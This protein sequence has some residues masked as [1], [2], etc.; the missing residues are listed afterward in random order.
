LGLFRNP[1]TFIPLALKGRATD[2]EAVVYSGQS[3][4]KFAFASA[5]LGDYQFHFARKFAELCAAHGI[6]LVVLSMPTLGARES[7]VIP[8][9]QPWDGLAGSSVD[10]VGIPGARLFAGV[11]KE[12]VAKL[13]YDEGHM[14]E[15]GQDYFTSLVTPVLLR[16]YGSTNAFN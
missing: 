13:F 12:D 11:P 9:H 3:S 2:A 16:L 4:D 6:H 7:P 10:L 8:L 15:T 5:P 14:N 1:A